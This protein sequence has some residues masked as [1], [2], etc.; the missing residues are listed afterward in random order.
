MDSYLI[1]GAAFRFP[2]TERFAIRVLAEVTPAEDESDALR[3]AA[4]RLAE[5][6]PVAEGWATTPPRATPLVA[7]QLAEVAA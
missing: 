6:G 4:A 1:A 3:I 7:M 5:L 2:D